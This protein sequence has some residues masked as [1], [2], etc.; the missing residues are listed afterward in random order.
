MGEVVDLADARRARVPHATGAARCMACRHEWVAVVPAGTEWL[1][2]PACELVRGRM[3]FPCMPESSAVFTC[4][5]GCQLF[6]VTPTGILCP[7]CAAWVT[8]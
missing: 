1:E 7:N 5:C 3:V 2:C 6:T 8:P 4:N